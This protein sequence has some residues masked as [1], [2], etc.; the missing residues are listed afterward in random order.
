MIGTPARSK[1]Q[2][3]LERR[4]AT[5]LNDHA[6]GFFPVDDV[7]HF[8]HGQRFEI[9]LVGGVVVRAHGLRIA[10]DHDGFVSFFS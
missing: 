4:L 3:Q 7:H 6:V 10:V 1:R 8:F 2:R 5:E 9:E